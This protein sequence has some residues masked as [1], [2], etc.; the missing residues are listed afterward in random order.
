MDTQTY[1]ILINS[2]YDELP[3]EAKYYVNRLITKA[4]KK[5]FVSKILKGFYDSAIKICDIEHLLSGVFIEA[6]L[7]KRAGCFW[8]LKAKILL[9]V[10]SL[11]TGASIPKLLRKNFCLFIQSLIIASYLAEEGYVNEPPYYWDYE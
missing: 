11:L 10:F 6:V 2:S 1:Q 9:V 3:R 7:N 4:S 5:P 8:Y